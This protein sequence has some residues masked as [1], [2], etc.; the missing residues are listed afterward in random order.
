[1]APQMTDE[2][3]VRALDKLVQSFNQ[4]AAQLEARMASDN[5]QGPTR[6]S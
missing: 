3:A 5:D 4:L 6:P 2:R 1:M